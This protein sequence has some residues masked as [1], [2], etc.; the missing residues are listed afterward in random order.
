MR[1]V[2]IAA[3]LVVLATGTAAD[4]QNSAS[5]TYRG[6]F[7]WNHPSGRTLRVKMADAR[8]SDDR[9]RILKVVG[10]DVW[11]IQF[12]YVSENRLSRGGADFFISRRTGDNGPRHHLSAP[13]YVTYGRGNGQQSIH[14]PLKQHDLATLARYSGNKLGAN[15]RIKA[16]S[17]FQ[18]KRYS[19]HGTGLA[20]ALRKLGYRPF[21]PR[22]PDSDLRPVGPVG[23]VGSVVSPTPQSRSAR[24][25]A[26]M[27]AFQLPADRCGKPTFGVIRTADDH[28]R[29]RRRA[30]DYDNC[31]RSLMRERRKSLVAFVSN[32]L[33]G[34]VTKTKTG[35]R[36][37]IGYCLCRRE[38]NAFIDRNTR[39]LQEG[40]KQIR[41]ETKSIA[42]TLNAAGERI[43]RRRREAAR[44]SPQ[45][46]PRR[47]Q[48]PPPVYQPPPPG[49][50]QFVRTPVIITPGLR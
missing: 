43:Q 23:S 48:P 46:P 16:G 32:D 44:P 5:W 39:V 1:S 47:F 36:Y 11:Y 9:L 7:D 33:G 45:P 27:R 8:V 26:R 38:F 13:A 21:R 19:F 35:W 12:I 18:L 4:A 15:Y 22:G 6:V 2:F 31:R 49:G 30:I 3:T 25:I 40:W 17:G 24:L 29:A 34:K 37:D 28:S 10:K 50:G 14:A 42:Q 20:D 41:A